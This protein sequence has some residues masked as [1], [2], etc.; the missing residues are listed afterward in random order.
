VAPIPAEVSETT[1]MLGSMLAA[2]VAAITLGLPMATSAQPAT[3]SPTTQLNQAEAAHDRGDFATAYRLWRPLAEQ[4]D[5]I[6]QY[7]LGLLYDNGQGVLQD[8]AD[9]RDWYLKAAEQG[10]AQAQFKFGLLYHVGRGVPQD[11]AAAVSWYR[12]AAEQGFAR[13]Q[14]NL[15]LMYAAG[16][17][18]AR[19]VVQAH[20]WYNLAAAGQ[21]D[22]EMR[23]V[24]ATGRDRLAAVMTPEQ[25][26]E[27]Q[28]LASAWRPR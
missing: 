23:E 18:V 12:K 13:A 10:L 19:D 11:Y 26:A 9:A 17:G 2:V 16:W 25:I 27:A 24:S 8:Y 20:K 15:G 4:G 6:A 1:M 5:A 7:N 21:T 28:R 22:H 3:T 14:N